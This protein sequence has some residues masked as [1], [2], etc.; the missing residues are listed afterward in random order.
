MGEL[1]AIPTIYKSHKFRSRIE[2]RWAVFYDAMG[3]AWEYEKEGYQLPSGWYLPD[4]W[5]PK[6]EYWIEIKGKEPTEKE[7]ALAQEL[8]VATKYPVFIF[9]GTIP[10]PEHRSDRPR[11]LSG[12]PKSPILC[13]YYLLFKKD[14]PTPFTISDHLGWCHCCLCRS[15]AIARHGD[16]SWACKCK[17]VGV[18]ESGSCTSEELTLEDAYNKVIQYDFKG[19]GHDG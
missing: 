17:G 19:A 8:C 18:K 11:C 1:K 6:Q 16:A 9:Y 12:T 2:A 13:G 4:F 3:I 7:V 5:L 10:D 15:S 14:H